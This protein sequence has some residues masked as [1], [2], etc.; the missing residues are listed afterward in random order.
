MLCDQALPSLGLRA[1]VE[2][3]TITHDLLAQ[4]DDRR[5]RFVC[6]EQLDQSCATF[7]ERQ[8]AQVDIDMSEEIEGDEGGRLLVGPQDRL[9]GSV[10]WNGDVNAALKPLEAG[11]PAPG[12]ERHDLAIEH[13]GPFQADAPLAECAHDLRKLRRL[14]VSES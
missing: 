6:V 13:H 3:A 5:R 1:L 11:G 7:D 12:I 10:A 14:F 2:V 8:R 9:R 4:S